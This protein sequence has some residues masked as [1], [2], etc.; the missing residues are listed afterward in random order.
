[1]STCQQSQAPAIDWLGCLQTAFHPHPITQ[2]DLVLL[3]NLPYV[4]QM[5]GIISKWATT[6]EM[7]SRYCARDARPR[8]LSSDALTFDLSLIPLSNPL[9]W[10]MVLHLLH[11]L[12][13]ALDS[14][15]S[16][17]AKN[18]SVA[19]GSTEGVGSHTHT[20]SPRAEQNEGFLLVSPLH[21]SP[22]AGNVVHWTLRADLRRC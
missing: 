11:T 3:H 19:L 15:F 1:M 7:S 16:E 22:P 14:R 18:L 12:V 21:R 10:Y 2:D 9:Q 20:H 5:S 17:T 4:V 13:P 8:P 6:H